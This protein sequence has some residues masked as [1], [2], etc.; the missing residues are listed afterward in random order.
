MNI[1]GDVSGRTCVLIDDIVDTAGT[2]CQAANALKDQGAR[3]LWLIA[4]TRF[5][6][7]CGR[8]Y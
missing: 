5:V 3:R 2:L 7:A 8:E 4:R 1:I 6:R